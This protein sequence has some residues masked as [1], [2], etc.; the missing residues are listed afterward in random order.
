MDSIMLKN[1]MYDFLRH[2]NSGISEVF[3]PI[4]ASAGLTPMQARLL[5]E[6]QA[7]GEMTVGQVSELICEN[8]GNCSSLCKRLEKSGFLLRER[9]RIDE[10]KVVLRLTAHA[11]QTLNHIEEEIERRC[12]P[13][14]RNMNAAQLEEILRCMNQLTAFVDCLAAEEKG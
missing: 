6:L 9:S 2:M 11:E 13:T 8:S 4:F 1:V 12:A 3:T 10:R 5:L 7:R 14:L